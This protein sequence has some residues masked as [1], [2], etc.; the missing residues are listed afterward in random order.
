MESMLSRPLHVGAHLSSAGG[1]RAM[2]ERAREMGCSSIQMFS[3]SPRIWKPAEL[4]EKDIHTFRSLAEEFK[5]APIYFHAS[6]LINLASEEATGERS[7]AALI[8]EL[9]TAA[10]LGVRGS[11]VHTGSF[12]GGREDYYSVVGR[13]QEILD[14]TPEETMLILENSGNRKIGVK[15]EQLGEIIKEV[16]SPRVRV[17]LDTCH[18]HAAGYDITTKEKLEGFLKEF[19]A[20]VGA[21]RLEVWHVN[22]S[23]DA[24]GSFRD[25]HDNLGEGF[26][27]KEVF[28]LLVNH[29]TMQDIPFILETPGFDGNGPDKKNVDILKSFIG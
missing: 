13:I 11:I 28:R 6:Y 14:S 16:G 17:C 4:K 8:H 21:E 10:Q 19:N 7:K 9:H 26:V 3:T 22:D 5:I 12:K 29:K 1:Y 24:F 20:V 2:F 18:L 25:R 23:R 27:G 15:L